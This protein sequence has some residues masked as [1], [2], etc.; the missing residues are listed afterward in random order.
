MVRESLEGLVQS[1]DNLARSFR[2]NDYDYQMYVF[3]NEYSNW[4]EEQRAVQETC[5]IVDQSY[6]MSPLYVDG[7]EAINFF[8]DLGVNSFENFETGTPPMAKNVVFCNRDGNVIRDVVLF[9]VGENELVSAGTEIPT[10]WIQYH[11]KEGDYDIS[12]EVPYRPGSDADPREFRFQVQGP[13][14][15][16]VM[17]KVTDE[18][19]PDFSFF[20]MNE[21]SIDAADTYALGFGMAATPGLEIFG[22]FE[23][24]DAILESILQVGEEYGMRRM[25][26][27]A[28][29][30]N[31][32]ATGWIHQPVPAIYTD[33][34]LEG[35]R[36]WVGVDGP[37]GKMSIGGSYESDDITDYYM[38]PIEC[39][40]GHL[41][42]F[43]HDF[44]GREALEEM[45]ENQQRERVTFVWDD[46]DVIDVYASLFEDGD[47]NKYINLPDTARQW[48]LT[49]YDK[50]L[51]DGDVIGL[52]KYPGY[53]YYEREMLSLGVVD[54]E[55][56][57][58]GTEL[59]LV[60]G[61]ENSAKNN[62]ERHV[63]AEIDV[64]VGP[65]PYLEGRRT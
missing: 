34:E 64:R 42:S 49:H 50:V 52:S 9:Y 61:E 32:I 43:D 6:H 28:Y 2:V 26:S 36:E 30:T 16:E 40:Q 33:D 44:I 1:S 65:A 62:V 20:E 3:P 27:K 22:P 54:V 14:A 57:D 47:T 5:I 29:K 37:E 31:K 39:G 7:P 8:S 41:I 55:Y 60:W 38:N 13:A 24:H 23:H 46:E 59:T 56:S 17:D 53:L 45:A 12:A 4:I 48:S 51:K 35:Y 11:L 63:E 21:I 19:L 15:M 58:A 10:N 25:G 18:P